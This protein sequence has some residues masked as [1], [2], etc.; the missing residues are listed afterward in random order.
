MRIFDDVTKDVEGIGETTQGAEIEN[1]LQFQPNIN[2]DSGR[3]PWRSMSGSD[4]VSLVC[5]WG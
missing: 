3:P 2:R 1:E 4:G 5:R